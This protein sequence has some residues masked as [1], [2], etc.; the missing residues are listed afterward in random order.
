M[1]KDNFFD[2][3]QYLEILE[4]RVSGFKHG[5]RQ[6]LAITG[7]ELV[8][9]TSLIFEFLNKFCD[10]NIIIMYLEVRPESLTLFTRMFIGVLLYNFLVNSGLPLEENLDFLMKKAQRFIPH[11]V[12]KIKSI[13]AAVSGRKKNNVFHYLLTLCDAINQE[14]G[15]SCVIVL[16]EFHNLENMGIKN[17]Y[18]EWSRLL[19]T[20]KST[21]YIIASSL[22]FKTKLILSKNLSLLFGNFE[23][24]SVEPFDIKTSEEYL[25]RK[26]AGFSL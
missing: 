24:I 20:Q 25:R 19:I 18:R 6:N 1:P 16:D 10:N 14:T 23:L 22:K 11:T 4:K 8:G 3:K 13:L 5:Y 21:M 26:L 15:K 12:E 17:L 7:D 2:R 9:K